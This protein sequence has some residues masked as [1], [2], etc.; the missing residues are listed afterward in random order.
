MRKILLLTAG[1]AVGFV[2][3]ARA[4]RPAYERIVSS[5]QRLAA[6]A[7]LD[8]AGQNVSAATVNLR[9]AV[10]DRTSA[11][12]REMSEGAAAGMADVADSVRKDAPAAADPL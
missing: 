6:A 7:G 10:A 3:G 1:G 12:V 4:G 2:L 8:V 5:Y 11:T 9:D